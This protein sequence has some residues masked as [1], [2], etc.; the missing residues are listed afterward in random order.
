MIFEMLRKFASN[1]AP[2]LL[3]GESGTGKELAAHSIHQYSDRAEGPFIAINCGAIPENLIEAELF[4]YEK[5]AFTGAVSRKEGKVEVAHG[6]TLF[7]DE[8]GELPLTL[9]VCVS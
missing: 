1:S 9:Q 8:V 3:T 4:G 5:G 2:V 7:L 6:G